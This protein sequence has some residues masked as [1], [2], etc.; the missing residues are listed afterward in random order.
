[1]SRARDLA[2]RVLHNRTHEDTDGGRE[3]ILTFKGEQSGGEI[4]TLAQ[5]QASHDGTSDDEKADLIFKTNDGSDGSSPTEAMRVD[6]SQHVLIGKTSTSSGSTV[7]GIMALNDGRVFATTSVTTSTE[8]PFMAARTS[9]AG[10]GKLIDF[11]YNGTSI[12]DISVDSSDNIQF[13]ATTAGGAG[14]YLHGSGGTDPFV[15]PMK[16]GALSDNENTLG[17][18]ARRFKDLYLGGGAYIGGTGASNKLEDYEEGTWTPDFATGSITLQANSAFYIKIGKLVTAGC[19]VENPTNVTSTGIVT[20]TG[21]PFTLNTS[22]YNNNIGSVWGNKL[23]SAGSFYIYGGSS[24][25][26]CSFYYGASGST[27]YSPVQYNSLYSDSNMI[28][29]FHYM[30]T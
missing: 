28:M 26:S 9:T 7:D 1:M 12:G 6:S 2:D 29:R 20:L 13:G 27:G 23:G 17:D 14:F 15:L 8:A 22:F 4:S 16:E 10:N 11:K 30:S 19:R 24:A 18:S 3:S 25:T 21:L 5:I